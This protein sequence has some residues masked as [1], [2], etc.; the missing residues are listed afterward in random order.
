MLVVANAHRIQEWRRVASALLQRL[1]S[2][3][4]IGVFI[5]C[6]FNCFDQWLM[7]LVHKLMIKFFHL[8][9]WKICING[10]MWIYP[11]FQ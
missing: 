11:F 8:I 1:F 9:F 7:S 4:F 10:N 5:I 2:I 6:G 3:S